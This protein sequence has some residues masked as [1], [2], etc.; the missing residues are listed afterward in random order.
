MFCCDPG[1]S[2]PGQA[3]WALAL[4]RVAQLTVT[5]RSEFARR[6]GKASQARCRRRH[7]LSAKLGESA[8]ARVVLLS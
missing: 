8:M 7:A 1:S 6:S 2:Q 3:A 5:K 4:A